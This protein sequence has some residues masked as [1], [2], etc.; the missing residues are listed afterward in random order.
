MKGILP[1]DD[2]E[3]WRHFVLACRI[4]CQH[5]L[6]VADISLADALLAQFCRRIERLYG[7]NVITP[8]MHMHCH[9]KQM[10]LDYGPAFGVFRMR[11]IMGY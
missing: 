4:M 11:D 2:L 1:N 8:N 10:L 3:C 6:S 7:K 5:S 9:Y